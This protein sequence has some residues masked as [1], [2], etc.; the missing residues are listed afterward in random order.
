MA[1]NIAVPGINPKQL[2]YILLQNPAC[3]KP[4]GYD[5]H[6][7]CKPWKTEMP[8][9]KQ[10]RS[11]NKL[12]IALLIANLA[13]PA[14]A[15]AGSV[16]EAWFVARRDVNQEQQAERDQ[17]KYRQPSNKQKQRRV[18]EEHGER[19]YGYGYERR[20]PDRPDRSYDD[21]GRR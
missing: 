14:V 3:G 7:Y 9:M 19:G 13:G 2:G 11:M 20:N 5:S 15:A 4:L 1:R 6:P 12:W 21:R 16:D 18:E 10:E 17:R 8:A